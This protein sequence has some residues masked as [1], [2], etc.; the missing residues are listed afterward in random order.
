M[1]QTIESFCCTKSTPD[2][3]MNNK[4]IGKLYCEWRI[5]LASSNFCKKHFIVWT[6]LILSN[7][8]NSV[9]WCSF[10]ILHQA[11]CEF[12][13]KKCISLVSLAWKF[14][15]KQ[16]IACGKTYELRK[17]TNRNEQKDSYSLF[18]DGW[19]NMAFVS[20][21]IFSHAF[22]GTISVCKWAINVVAIAAH[23]PLFINR[24]NIHCASY[25]KQYKA[26]FKSP[27]WFCVNWKWS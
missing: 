25:A 14:H 21:L 4:W 10:F 6:G 7:A 26:S 9:F 12:R 19:L 18:K 15:Q 13:R 20:H 1:F 17:S 23:N 11:G 2:K 24:V 5:G 8:L 22:S 16:T 27:E 3:L